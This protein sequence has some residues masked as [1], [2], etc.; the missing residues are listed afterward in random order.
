MPIRSIGQLPS[1]DDSSTSAAPAASRLQ[2]PVYV[3]ATSSDGTR[4]ALAAA[5]SHARDLNARIVM[6]VPHVVP[7]ARSIE[8]PVVSPDFVADRFRSL[9]RELSLEVSIH[10]CL[11]RPQDA[12]LAPLVPEDAVILLGGRARR[13]WRT[14]EQRLAHALRRA[15]HRVLFVQ[16]DR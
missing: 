11:C 2:L 5:R 7:Y 15:G 9:A 14:R 16:A 12:A 4:T 6:L 13:W 8:H 3:L 10:V 1:Q